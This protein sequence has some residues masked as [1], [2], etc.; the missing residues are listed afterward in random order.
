M[1][2]EGR[3][4][5]VPFRDPAAMADQVIDLLANES[6][7]HAMRKRA[8]MF[9]RQMIWPQ[10]ARLYMETFERARAKRRHFAGRSITA[11]SLDRQPR[12]L[13]PLKLNHLLHMTDETGLLQH[14]LFTV[15]NYR[16]GY[17][18]DDNARAL[19]VSTLLEALGRGEALE[20]TSRYLAF[21]WY[22]FN[23]DTGR[24]RN[25]MDYDRHWLEESG[26]EDSHGRAL[27]ALG[28]VLGRSNT[29][30]LQS[31]ADQ[32][33]EKAL[34][35][36]LDTTSPRAWAFALIGIHEYL[37]RFSG[38]RRASQVREDL[39][40][41]LLAL[42]ASHRSDAWR[43]Y[44]DRLTYCNAVMPHALLLCGQSMANKAM[45]EAGLE[46]LCWLT[47]LQHTDSDE[48]H[49]IPIGSSG[50]YV[51]GGERAQFDQQPIEA[52]SMVSACLQAYRITD[53]KRWRRDARR[54]FE[55]FLGR[56]DLNLPLYDAT[57]GGCRDGLHPDRP[58]ENQGA[59]STLAFLHAL[60]E[61][62]LFEN[63]LIPVEA[64]SE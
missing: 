61:L 48:G 62:R 23:T 18:T 27:L 11:K 17:T 63:T 26:S 32:V 41:R 45:A 13:P 64:R 22:A 4:A 47:D 53:D 50:F 1:L 5:L 35:A 7:R 19:T 44:E 29:P 52:Q 46:S 58:N 16:E 38:D 43:W 25:F 36:I 39:A 51:Q 20:L 9:G 30:A 60:L 8:Y 6:K 12:E 49:F 10:V 21:V 57:T 14:A 15:P 55:W 2:A 42:Y 37:R 3:G 31:M 59:E 33:F 56:N 54:A 40:E 34:P 28:T 24:F